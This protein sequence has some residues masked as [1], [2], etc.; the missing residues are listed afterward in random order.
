MIINYT[1]KYRLK[2]LN[3]RII[4]LKDNIVIYRF[5]IFYQSDVKYLM[6]HLINNH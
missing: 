6:K 3:F 2:N 1:Q 5:K 4:V